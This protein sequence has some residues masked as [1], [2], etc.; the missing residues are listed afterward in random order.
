[1]TITKQAL[2]FLV[3]TLL[4]PATWVQAHNNPVQRF[5]GQWLW[6]IEHNPQRGSA[7]RYLIRPGFVRTHDTM[8]FIVTPVPG[9]P[10]NIGDN[11][12]WIRE[13]AWR[14][15]PE[16]TMVIGQHAR[17]FRYQ[18]SEPGYVRRKMTLPSA[19]DLWAVA[20]CLLSTRVDPFLPSGMDNVHSLPLMMNGLLSP[21]YRRGL[22]AQ[23]QPYGELSREVTAGRQLY[24]HSNYEPEFYSPIHF[25]FSRHGYEEDDHS[26]TVYHSQ[27]RTFIQ[28][29]GC[30]HVASCSLFF[31]G[32]HILA[33]TL[34]PTG[35]VVILASHY[36]LV[37]LKWISGAC[38][39]GE[40]CMDPSNWDR[41]NMDR[42]SN[43]FPV[44]T[45]RWQGI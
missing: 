43:F 6:L 26:Q 23:A 1:M 18:V 35:N 45:G 9:T 41:G 44:R 8:S 20:Q 30:P 3:C 42:Q 28:L 10:M 33:S 7:F 19:P 34:D 13:R 27:N 21:A 25:L 2:V 38:K 40:N 24:A 14:R 22:L 11:I 39:P 31:W 4:S 12:N 36:L 29:G 5:F 37:R 15:E 16:T 32:G 17:Q